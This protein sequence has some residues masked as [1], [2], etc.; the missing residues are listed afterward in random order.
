MKNVKK[1]LAI[2]FMSFMGVVMCVTNCFAA[3]GYTTM[4]TPSN[5]SFKAYMS[6]RAI[7]S[8]NSPQYKLQQRAYTGNY[9]IR[10]VDDRYC[11]AVGSYYTTKIGTKIDVLMENGTVIKCVLADCKAN[12]H[13]DSTNRANPNGGI[14]EFIVDINNLDSTCRRMG[15][16]SY[17]SSG[18]LKGEVQYIRVYDDTI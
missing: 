2:V 6:Y 8:T 18:G 9:G 14:V 1:R 12:K 15:D 13:T 4:P 10:M 17:V 16:M 3:G 11:I 5:N 7:T